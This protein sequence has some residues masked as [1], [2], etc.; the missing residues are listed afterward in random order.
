M[1][2]PL[3]VK[4]KNLSTLSGAYRFTSLPARNGLE[5]VGGKIYYAINRSLVSL[6]ITKASFR[7]VLI[8]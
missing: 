7:P 1:L 2:M 3:R 6:S 4:I 8:P 5:Y